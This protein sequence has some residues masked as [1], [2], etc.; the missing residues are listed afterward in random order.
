MVAPRCCIYWCRL[1]RAFAA[2]INRTVTS[3]H[4]S[5]RIKF[6]YSDEGSV[7]PV[8]MCRFARAFAEVIYDSEIA[9][10]ASKRVWYLLDC[11]VTKGSGEPVQPC[12]YSPEP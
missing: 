10:R 12:E 8:R 1:A 9:F 7:E 4:L 11:R 5:Q 6:W 2:R 3:R